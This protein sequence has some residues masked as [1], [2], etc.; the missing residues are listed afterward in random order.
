MRQLDKLARRL[1][2]S[3]PVLSHRRGLMFAADLVDRVIS[4]PIPEFRGLPPNRLRIRSGSGNQLF[5]NQRRFMAGG[6]RTLERLLRRDLL[7]LDSTV[8]TDVGSGS[9]RFALALYRRGFKGRYTGLDVDGEAISWCRRTFPSQF[10]FH[11][12]DVYSAVYNPEGTKGSVVFPLETESQD[13][14]LGES[15][16]TH[17]LEDDVRS[18][19]AESVRILRTGGT[20]FMSVFCLDHLR[21]LD[22]L[23][24]RW[25]FGHRA[26]VA[27]IESEVYPEA[28]VAYEAEYLR[29]A[30]EAV[31]FVNVQLEPGAQTL[32]VG[33]AP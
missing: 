10:A 2:P 27:Y 13:L 32:L 30:A 7:N 5:F 17:L 28:A 3:V 21:E 8:L 25:T 1:L 33:E 9:G 4:W 18:Y 24:G 14:V 15:L 26:G 29:C 6:E 12:L 19:L 20:F 23:G 31:G 11:R 16:L 22:L